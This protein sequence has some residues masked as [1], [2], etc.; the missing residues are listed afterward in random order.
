VPTSR[1]GGTGGY[2]SEARLVKWESFALC[3]EVVLVLDKP[4]FVLSSVVRQQNKALLVCIYGAGVWDR[5][6]PAF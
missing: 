2:L 6:S 1:T 3:F 5:C 4:V